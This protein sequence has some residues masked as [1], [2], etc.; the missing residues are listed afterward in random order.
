[1]NDIASDFIFIETVITAICWWSVVSEFSLYHIGLSCQD[2]KL[3][4]IKLVLI[5]GE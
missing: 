3:N 1:M 2:T 4:R 5:N